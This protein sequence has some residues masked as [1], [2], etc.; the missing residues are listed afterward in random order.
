MSNGS[1]F[2]MTRL[3]KRSVIVHQPIEK[4]FEFF[5]DAFVSD[6]LPDLVLPRRYD[7]LCGD[8]STDPTS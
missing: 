5:A 7:S 3:V 1:D 8:A 4:V 2:T 6:D